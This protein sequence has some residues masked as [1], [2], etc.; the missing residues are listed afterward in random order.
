VELAAANLELSQEI[1]HRKATEEA[2]K[3]SERHYSQLLRQSDRLQN[4]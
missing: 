3:K 4:K 1:A 2:L